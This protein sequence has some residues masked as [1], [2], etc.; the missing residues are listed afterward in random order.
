[1]I[2][3][4]VAAVYRGG[5]RIE[6][7]FDDGKRGIVVL[8]DSAAVARACVL[9]SANALLRVPGAAGGRTDM[10]DT[11]PYHPRRKALPMRTQALATSAR[12]ALRPYDAVMDAAHS[13][14][15]HGSAHHARVTSTPR[16]RRAAAHSAGSVH[17]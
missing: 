5:Y 13:R 6:L 17:G 1:M 4:L 2:H 3:D 7:E 8:A 14:R 11:R 10:S 9:T 16:G 12:L 15:S